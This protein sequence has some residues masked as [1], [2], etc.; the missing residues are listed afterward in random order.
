MLYDDVYCSVD[1]SGAIVSDSVRF[2]SGW[3]VLIAEGSKEAHLKFNIL[4]SFGTYGKITSE[5]YQGF[6]KDQVKERTDALLTHVKTTL[7]G[8]KIK[9]V[10]SGDPW[11]YDTTACP[12]TPPPHE[13]ITFSL[14][15]NSPSDS[16]IVIKKGAL[17]I[18]C[19]TYEGTKHFNNIIIKEVQPRKSQLLKSITFD[20]PIPPTAPFNVSSFYCELEVQYSKS[21]KKSVSFNLTTAGVS[22]VFTLKPTVVQL[23]KTNNITLRLSTLPAEVRAAETTDFTD[24]IFYMHMM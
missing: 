9:E 11:K 21:A 4:D 14:V 23:S 10:Q 13:P 22:S 20:G 16:G 18:V 7:A 15:N 6:T 19:E 24:L 2:I 1:S 5:E 12:Y 8:K 17:S 3:D